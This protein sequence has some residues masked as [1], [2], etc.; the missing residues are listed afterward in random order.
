[1]SLKFHWKIVLVFIFIW[2]YETALTSQFLTHRYGAARAAKKARQKRGFCSNNIMRF[3]HWSFPPWCVGPPSGGHQPHI[4]LSALTSCQNQSSPSRRIQTLR[5]IDLFLNISF[6][7]SN[8]AVVN[9]KWFG[10]NCYLLKYF[11]FCHF[12]QFSKRSWSGRIWWTMWPRWPGP[13]F[14]VTWKNT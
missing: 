12:T 10:Q 6:R 11:Y 4:Y 8:V 5:Q 13:H 7:I 1:M 14:I 3:K 9:C 2:N